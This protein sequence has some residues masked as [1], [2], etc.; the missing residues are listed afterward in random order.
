MTETSDTQDE[1]H[2]YIKIPARHWDVLY[3]TL[4]LDS[5]SCAF[6]QV[7]QDQI[8]MA[9]CALEVIE[10]PLGNPDLVNAYRRLWVDVENGDLDANFFEHR[11]TFRELTASPKKPIFNHLYTLAITL[12]T[13]NDAESV[14]PRELKNAARKRLRY[15]Q[16]N[17]EELLE[18]CGQP[19]ATIEVNN[20]SN[21]E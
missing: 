14:T 2:L 1:P 12:D 6:D 17:P 7:T 18:A 4:R 10:P 16:D 20:G 15:L 3:Q 19:E 5:E 21:K 13:D 11:A 9:L 8:L